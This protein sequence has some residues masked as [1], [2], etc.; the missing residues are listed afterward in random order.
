MPRPRFYYLDHL[1]AFAMLFGILVH[2]TK[3]GNFGIFELVDPISNN[4]RMG[5]FYVLSGF[6][7]GM[8][9][10]RR[11][12]FT[13][14][15]ERGL[16]IGLPFLSTL[17]LL[18]PLTLWL[19]YNIHNPP[20]PLTKILDIVRISFAGADD[21]SGEIVWHLHLWFLVAL[22]VYIVLAGPMYAVIQWVVL[23]KTLRRAVNNIPSFLE[24]S[25]LAFGSALAVMAM[26]A[27]SSLTLGEHEAFWIVRATLSYAPWYAL[28]LLCWK[29]RTLWDRMHRFDPVL[30][31]IVIAFWIM[32]AQTDVSGPIYVLRRTITIVAILCCLLYIFR[33]LLDR[34]IPTINNI[35][36]SAYSIYLFHY[37]VVYL[38]ATI[39][40][41]FLTR[42]SLLL[43]FIVSICTFAVAYALHR[44]VILRLPILTFFFNG[45]QKNKIPKVK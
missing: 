3:I 4:F 38:L 5:V 1:R 23:N 28:G 29:E 42:D 41:P 36:N 45:K 14:L 8:L 20:V 37:F 44:M 12:G 31:C 43:Y 18:N 39:L 10:D 35:T 13:F 32:T 19:I 40:I 17:L 16:V 22:F 34:S 15:K 21:V 33:W 24:I 27:I 2:T 9:L 7:G 26:R 6:F 30:L 25:V 11:G